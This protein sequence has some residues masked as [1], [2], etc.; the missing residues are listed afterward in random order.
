MTAGVSYNTGRVGAVCGEYT[1]L[2]KH[3][4]W[5]LD[6]S[7]GDVFKKNAKIRTER[8]QARKDLMDQL[9]EAM[10]K[11]QE[12][13]QKIASRREQAPTGH[14]RAMDYGPAQPPIGHMGT[15]SMTPMTPA[16]AMTVAPGIPPPGGTTHGA[17]K[18]HGTTTASPSC[19]EIRAT[20]LPKWGRSL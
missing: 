18:T 11:L 10:D 20:A 9:F 17:T 8:E 16:P 4:E 3:L 6:G 15:P 19:G 14:E 5:A 2:K 12:N 1:K 7:L 13:M